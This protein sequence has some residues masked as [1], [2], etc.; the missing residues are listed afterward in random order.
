M[1]S[2]KLTAQK[3]AE[4]QAK[5]EKQ[6]RRG[7]TDKGKSNMS[8]YAVILV[9][10]IVVIA[11]IYFAFGN[12]TAD[13]IDNDDVITNTDPVAV[14]DYIVVGKSVA[15]SKIDFK[16]NDND[17]DGDSLNVTSLG[18]PSN[19][20]FNTVDGITYYTRTE[21]FTGTETVE[22]T[23]DDG[24]GGSATSTIHIIV[25]DP[26]GNPIAIIDT[27]K[28][29][30]VVELYEDKVPNTCA[31]FINLANDG[32]YDGLVFHR[33]MDYF[34]IQGGGFETDGSQKQS[35]YG[36]IDLEIHDD[37]KH[38]DGAIAM[39]RTP[40]PNSATSQFFIND[41]AQPDLEPGGVDQ[42]GYAVFGGVTEGMEVVRSI[43][44]V[45]TEVKYVYHETWPKDDV[46]I[47]S[48]TIENQ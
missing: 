35:P 16:A 3:R 40:D 20:V 14:E 39:A 11:G 10:I 5:R 36:T 12:K 4:L 25:V 19:G 31:N 38:V 26:D 48:I 2:R 24:M 33:V 43:A 37:L 21:N 13:V 1:P 45:D 46:V 44:S 47:N 27:S 34:M 32:F 41:G 18:D 8:L 22:Y 28:G 23:I 29:T 42:Y 6:V 7:T 17:P 30:I 9:V 15:Q